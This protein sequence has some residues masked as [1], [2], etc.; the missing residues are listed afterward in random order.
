MPLSLNLLKTRRFLPLFLTQF[1]GAFNDNLYKNALVILITYAAAS[2]AKDDAALMVTAAAGIFILPFF[3]FS[4]TAGQLA[5]KYNRAKLIRII[6]VAEIVIMALAA[7]GFVTHAVWLLMLALFAMGTHSA[8]F[9]PIKYAILR[10]HLQEQELL[11]G[12]ALVSAATFVAIL[13]GTIIGGLV[14][15]TDGG[16]VW[17]SL[18]V[19]GVAVL[20]YVAS[21]F[22]LPT[23]PASPG[24]QVNWNFL[25]ESWRLVQR[26][27]ENRVVF[28]AI[29]AISWFWLV[30]ATFLAQFPT[31]AKQ[32]LHGDETVVTLL[33]TC[34]TIGIALGSLLCNRLLKGEISR[35]YVPRAAVCMA[36][37]TL[38]L[39]AAS[40]FAA[41]PEEGYFN[42]LEWLSYPISWLIG[43]SMLA[44][45]ISGGVYV[46]P[47][48]ALMQTKSE[49]ASR[50]RVIASNNIMNALFMVLSSLVSLALLAIGV[51]VVGLFLVTGLWNFA[52]AYYIRER[53]RE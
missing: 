13:L 19:I 49:A 31:Y 40:P 41:M 8:F 3:L 28:R 7:L 12:N 48:Y 37:A 51:S 25:A 33:L 35:R 27:R 5:D 10:D 52:V 34:F 18:G 22:V 1:C 29:L 21:R 16:R 17:I 44:I 36:L 45:A 46:V 20:G 30:G 26:A 39:C 14:I 47:L 24:L 15:L 23:Q 2:H 32:V 9:G 43:A 38:A 11:A 50:A 42:A 4:A 6:K 53:D